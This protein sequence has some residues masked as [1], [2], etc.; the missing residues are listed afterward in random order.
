M[1]FD[2]S[3]LFRRRR[4]LRAERKRRAERRNAGREKERKERI[5]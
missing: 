3:N 4:V 1:T 5:E 2:A